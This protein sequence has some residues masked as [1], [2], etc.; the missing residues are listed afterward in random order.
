MKSQFLLVGVCVLAGA[1]SSFSLRAKCKERG[2]ELVGRRNN[3]FQEVIYDWRPSVVDA[4]Q[5]SDAAGL[6]ESVRS[7]YQFLQ[8]QTV[9]FRIPLWLSIFRCFTDP[10]FTNSGKFQCPSTDSHAYFKRPLLPP[11]SGQLQL[12][13][14][15]DYR[16]WSSDLQAKHGR[17]SLG[18]RSAARQFRYI[19]RKLPRLWNSRRRR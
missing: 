1:G 2:T 18:E 12:A 7:S 3:L 15:F 6:R 11:W 16:R 9:G 8:F 13:T 10:R 5:R 14:I 4:N 17:A 19:F